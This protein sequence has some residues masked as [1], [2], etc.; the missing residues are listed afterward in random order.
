MAHRVP[1]RGAPPPPPPAL[2]K[3][4]RPAPEKAK[5]I[6]PGGHASTE[7][8]AETPHLEA[9]PGAEPNSPEREAQHLHHAHAQG[10]APEGHAEAKEAKEAKEDV[11]KA[12]EAEGEGTDAH[13][14]PLLGPKDIKAPI[15]GT[16]GSGTEGKK[17]NDGFE[18]KLK[19]PSLAAGKLRGDALTQ[20]E[21][22]TASR[23]VAEASLQAAA[24][25]DRPPD[26]LTLLHSAK[27]PGTLFKEDDADGNAAEVLPSD[28]GL[29]DAVEEA[30]RRLFGTRGIMRIGSGRNEANEPVVVVVAAPGFNETSLKA[31]PPRIQ[32]FETLLAIPYEL[33]PLK[34]ERA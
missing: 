28:A 3:K 6:K 24:R 14:K 23:K 16:S 29:A 20:K 31:I 5:I 27:E 12:N 21:K 4:P 13:G 25:T 19:E 10:W 7:E 17:Q 22:L 8:V 33:L 18:K 30:I 32:R 11:A 15:K 9:S 2:A 34:K 1:P 26:A